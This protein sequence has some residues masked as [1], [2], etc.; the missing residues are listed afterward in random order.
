MSTRPLSALVAAATFLVFLA[1]SAAA[2]D[3]EAGKTVFNRCKI[4][5]RVEA[6]APSA[7]GPNLHGLFG[8]KAG[9]VEGYDYSAAMKNSGVTWDEETL[10]KYLGDPKGFIPGNKMAF[11]G[12]K[13]QSELDNVLAY[14]KQATQ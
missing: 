3:P 12:L 1:A 11:P 5:H 8:R 9:T 10:R 7:L 4:C 2:A 6:G 13:N 14:L